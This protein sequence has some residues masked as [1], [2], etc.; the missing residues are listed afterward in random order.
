MFMPF[1][2]LGIWVRGLLSVV[3]LALGIGLLRQWYL[4]RTWVEQV[5]ADRAGGA[6]SSPANPGRRPTEAAGRGVEPRVHTWH[7]GLNRQTAYL[8]GGLTLLGLSLGGG[9]LLYP[10]TRPVGADEPKADHEGEVRRLERPD[11]TVLHVEF[12]GPENAPTLVMTHGWGADSTEWYYTKK[13]LAKRFRLIVWDLPGLGRSTSPVDRDWSLER[14]AGHLD[15]VVDL[16]GKRPVTL[17]GHSIGGM[18]ILTFCR[19]F[20]E[21]LGPRVSGLILVHTSYTNP[22]K[23]TSHAPIVTAIQKP[24]L[25]PLC[26]LMIGLAPLVW[27]MNWLSYLNGSIQQQTHSSAF[28]GHETRGQLEFV[29]WYQVKA[30]PSVVARGFLGMF[31]YDATS[32]LDKIDIPTLVIVADK[33][34]TTKPEAG[35]HIASRVPPANSSTLAPARHM[36]LIEQHPRF[37]QL[38]EQFVE[39]HA[40]RA[41]VAN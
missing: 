31:R 37:N 35:E 9:R 28:A 30:W 7:F 17:V 39:T 5:P 8:L 41:A 36:G 4:E 13:A 32:I 14:L 24:I 25:E 10:L 6:N 3:V 40:N 18:T 38:V 12:H 2:V 34:T 29:S 11:G 20:R 26:Y 19:L 1:Q 16:A 22:V 33:D 23:T 15:A 27:L 21:S